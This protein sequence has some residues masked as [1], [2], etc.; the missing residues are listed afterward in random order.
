MS[1]EIPM[2]YDLA[3]I[4]ACSLPV[5][6]LSRRIG[7]PPI[8]GFVLTG[9]LIG[10]SGLGF[11]K[12]MDH[13]ES[14][15][16]VGVILLLFIVGLELS[17][18]GLKSMSHRVLFTAIAQ[19]I[20]TT[21]VIT[22]LMM[23]L[24]F[25]F[26]T[27][28][29]AGFIV[30]GSSSAVVLK[31]LADK[32]ELATTMGQM[33]V[34]I[35][36]VT[37]LAAVPMM[38]TL[39]IL[40]SGDFSMYFVSIRV[41]LLVIWLLALY[42]LGRWVIPAL[43][44]WL[45]KIQAPEAILLFAILVLLVIGALSSL[46]GLSLA[47]GA[48]AAGIILSEN[49]FTAHIYSQVQSFGVLF[50]SLFFVSIGML[51]DLSFVAMN[52]DKVVLVCA[53]VVVIKTV[54]VV[55]I[56]P[57]L[58]MTLRERVQGGIYLAQISEFSFVLLS[59]A[60]ASA[61]ITNFEFQ[62]FIAASSVTLALTPLIMQI[63]PHVAYR[64]GRRLGSEVPQN[65][66]ELPEQSRPKPAVLIVGFGLNGHNVA[67]VL[68]EA[69]IYYEIL[70]FNPKTV[71]QAR[72]E[73]EIIHYGDVTHTGFLEYLTVGEFDSVVLAISDPAATRRAVT[74]IHRLNPNAHLIVRTKYVA[75]VE[76]LERLGA[77]L[78]VPEEF[79]TS[80]RIFVELLTHYHI[81]PHIV[82][83]QVEAVR[84]QSYG[85]LRGTAIGGDRL[86]QLLMQRLVEAVPIAENSKARAKTLHALGFSNESRCQVI[87]L[88]RGGCSYAGDFLNTPLEVNDL[89][90][91]YGDHA[92]LNL[93]V[94]AL[95]PPR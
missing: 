93:G 62:Y 54:V 25:S 16:E 65:I 26:S 84:S 60:L 42:L 12:S 31:P 76:E 85:A 74:T 88:L 30:T 45:V 61:L 73:G 90:V 35:C 80:L 40:G 56:S 58:G 24:G 19:V 94:A 20:V 67:R 77:T 72:D 51:M 87:A 79:E 70:E 15:A 21:G 81:P 36:V 59:A 44:R 18:S 48:F 23:S 38:M 43:M 46:A 91:L 28:L 14:S 10:P 37:D 55:L 8:A 29:I 71:Q 33:V 13:V 86:S 89:V 50:S 3:I 69:G 92:A 83:A 27:S 4:L 39:G 34:A 47:L 49:E 2:F 7:L 82:A 57:G 68:R 95:V 1:H 78:V 52:F 5:L 64:A 41:A 63:A 9:I 11:I 6:F 32:G 22:A 75:E 17:L 53:A 66:V